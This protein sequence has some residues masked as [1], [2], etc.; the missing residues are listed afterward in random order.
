MRRDQPAAKLRQVN[1]K[2]TSSTQVA[3][4]PA[5]AQEVEKVPLLT[6]DLGGR[7]E[8]FADVAKGYRLAKP[9]GWNRFEGE[10][11]EYVVKLVDLVDRSMGVLLV[12]TPVKSDTEVGD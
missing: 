6:T 3:P 10:P 9:I 2:P 4:A 8:P 5:P 1:P 12:T 7:L 11:G